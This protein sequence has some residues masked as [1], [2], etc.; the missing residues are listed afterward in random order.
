MEKCGDFIQPLRDV[1]EFSMRF[2][3]DFMGMEPSSLWEFKY[4]FNTV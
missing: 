2:S 3:R 4:E 1:V